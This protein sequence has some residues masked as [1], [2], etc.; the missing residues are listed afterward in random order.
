MLLK[1]FNGCLPIEATYKWT[2][3]KIETRKP[4]LA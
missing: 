3:K 2:I 1:L 4:R